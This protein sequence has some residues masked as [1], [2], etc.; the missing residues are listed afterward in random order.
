M[1]VIRLETSDARWVEDPRLSDY[2]AVRDPELVRRGARFLAEG[3]M[4]VRTLLEDS[5]YKTL[6]LLADESAW[7]ALSV[8]VDPSVLERTTSYVVPA[9]ALRDLGGWKFHQG[10]LAVGQ[11]PPTRSVAELLQA[12]PTAT[13][14]VG[15]D[16]VSNPDNVGAIFRSAAALGAG[17]IALSPTCASPLYRKAVR[18]SM[19][20]ALRLPF[21]HGPDWREGLQAFQAR[22]VRLLALT[23]EE[24]AEELE[25][26]AQEAATGAVRVVLLGAEGSGLG[27]VSLEHADR[28]VRIPMDGGVDSLNVAAAAA[29]ALYRLAR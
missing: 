8:V 11:R 2:R 18:T 10:C 5:P 26:V 3:R 12:N 17:G 29:V 13:L 27:A 20:A 23:P 21:S 25:V 14:W 9:G 19:G 4:V 1:S 22:G 24:G 16:D 6:S 28:R 7:S 15:L